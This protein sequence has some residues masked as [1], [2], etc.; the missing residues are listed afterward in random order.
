M[1]KGQLLLTWLTEAGFTAYI[2]GGA[3]RDYVMG[4]PFHDIDIATSAKPEEVL[5]VLD[6]HHVAHT[7]LV[8]KN[9]GVVVATLDGKPYEIATFRGERYGVHSHKP[10][11][12]WYADTWEE[13]V[14][15][16]DFTINGLA[17]D[18]QGQVI[19]LVGGVQDCKKRVLRTIG[20]STNRFHEDPLRLFRACRFI[21]QLNV[22]P[23]RSLLDGMAKAFPRVAGLSLARVK[24]ELHKLLVSPYVAKGLDVLVQ[25]GLADCSCTVKENGQERIIPILPELHH[26]VNLPQEPMFHRFDGWYHTLAVVQ[27]TKPD[28]LL[29]WAAL[30]H[31][32]GK[33]MPTVRAVRNGRLTDHSHDEVGAKMAY[34]LLLRLQYTPDFAQ[35]VSWLV[36][37]HM[38]FHYFASH[39]EADGIKWA[40]KEALSGNFRNARELQEAWNQLSEICQADVIGCGNP[41]A[42]TASTAAFGEYMQ[43]IMDRM[44]IQSKDLNYD[45]RVVQVGATY[46]AQLMKFLIRQVQDGHT[47]NKPEALYQ[48][49]KQKIERWQK[50]KGE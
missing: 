6:A 28:L 15:R 33:G 25:S 49:A 31:D 18:K 42:S 5:A 40:R 8:G 41:N 29:R 47:P 4:R 43:D 32:V 14:K 19:D 13:D 22:L 50:E 1:E 45:E 17:M 39:D 7:D 35:R 48:A 20:N 3:V 24:E 37:R 16:R 26:L 12:V 46:M 9:F 36:A 11:E 23:H 38:R 44:P 21:G 27:H 10:E 34:D 2:V 30:L